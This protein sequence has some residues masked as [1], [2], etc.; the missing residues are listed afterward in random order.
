MINPPIHVA[1]KRSSGYHTPLRR[2]RHFLTIISDRQPATGAP[3]VKGSV[4]DLRA[5]GSLLTE[6]SQSIGEEARSDDGL[7]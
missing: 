4:G 3:T 6:V 5:E 2:T 1:L 7:V